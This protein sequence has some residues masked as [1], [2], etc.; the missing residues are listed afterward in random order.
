VTL[1]YLTAFALSFALNRVFNFRSHEALGGQT[2]KYVVAVAINCFWQLTGRQPLV[3]FL[4]AQDETR[5]HDFSG[6][7]LC[8]KR[9]APLL[10]Q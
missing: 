9:L 3:A 2:A 6:L 1:S 10:Q 7:P 8:I 5:G 4:N